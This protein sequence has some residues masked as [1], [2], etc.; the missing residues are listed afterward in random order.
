VLAQD[1]SEEYLEDLQQNGGQF[2]QLDLAES[3]RRSYSSHHQQF[4]VFLQRAGLPLVPSARAVAQF[5]VA[6]AQHGYAFSTIE[7]GVYALARWGLDLGIEGLAQTL[8]VRRA[9]AVA[10]KLAVPKDGQKWPLERPELRQVVQ[11]LREKGDDDFVAVRDAALFLV[12]WWHVSMLRAGEC[13][14]GGAALH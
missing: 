13:G 4:F 10:N 7:Q 1:W 5:T 6:R 11:Y 14:V 12:G 2:L 9:L 8:E 3:T